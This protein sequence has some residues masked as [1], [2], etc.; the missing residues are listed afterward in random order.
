MRGQCVPEKY[1]RS[2]KEMYRG[3]MTQVRSSVGMTKECPVKVGLHQGSALSLHPFD[4]IMDVLVKDVKKEAPWN[5]MFADDVVLCEQSIDK[6]EEK[7]EEWRKAVE[8]RG[9]KISRTKDRKPCRLSKSRGGGAA[10]AQNK[11]EAALIARAVRCGVA[12]ACS[13]A[14]GRATHSAA[15][16]VGRRRPPVAPARTPRYGA[17]H[18]EKSR[19]GAILANYSRQRHKDA[20]ESDLDIPSSDY[21]HE[22]YNVEEGDIV[23]DDTIHSASDSVKEIINTT[24]TQIEYDDFVRKNKKKAKQS[25]IRPKNTGLKNVPNT[26]NE[27][28]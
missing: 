2:V 16:R 14:V 26:S 12:A 18:S 17:A 13:G 11:R 8:E 28:G 3:A 27:N 4:L 25:T 1:V 15:P 9:M 24:V 5:M 21:S 7:L 20:I 23:S 22:D 6:L 19:S 10:R